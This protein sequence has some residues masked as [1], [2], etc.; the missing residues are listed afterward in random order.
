MKKILVLGAGAMG[1]AFTLPCIE[2]KNKVILVGTH[3]ENELV[4][5]LNKNSFHPALNANLPK[6]LKISKFEAFQYELKSN[7]D[8]IVLAVSSNG[9]EWACN[10]LIKNYK[11]KLSI[12]LLTKGLTI[13]NNEISTISKKINSIFTKNGLP[14]QDITSI[15]GPCLATGLINKIRTGTVI[16]NKDISKAKAI[17]KIISTDY[18]RTEISDDINGVEAAG[19]IKNIYSM[20]IGASIGLSGEK[21]NNYVREKF[22]HNTASVLFKNSLTEI[23]KFVKIMGGKENTAYGLA[24][25]GDLYVSVVGG[26]N[27]LMGMYLGKGRLYLDVKKKDMKNITVEGADLAIEIGPKLLKKLKKK[28]FPIMFSLINAIYKNKKLKINW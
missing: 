16:A 27:S 9:I 10:E 21:L 26:R 20:V 28:D 25:L 8:Y 23:Q 5:N 12:I 18:Y 11:N 1:S 13:L 3:L 4:K 6:N 24:G 17:S 15:K 2:N 19:A 7:P 14:K 22:Y